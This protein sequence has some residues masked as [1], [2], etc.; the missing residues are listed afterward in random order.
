MARHL[1]LHLNCTYLSNREQNLRKS[2]NKPLRGKKAC[3]LTRICC[4]S[5]GISCWILSFYQLLPRAPNILTEI[6][7]VCSAYIKLGGG[8]D[9]ITTAT[10]TVI[11]VT[12]TRL[13]CGQKAVSLNPQSS[14]QDPGREQIAVSLL[15]LVST[16]LH[17]ITLHII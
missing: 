14:W 9:S 12:I 1:L 17:Y 15:Q 11:F 8:A 5:C 13:A 2:N 16:I 10:Q 3:L 6:N 4:F 7:D